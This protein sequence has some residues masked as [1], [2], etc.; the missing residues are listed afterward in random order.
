MLEIVL[1]K[2]FIVIL[3]FRILIDVNIF[4][5]EVLIYIKEKSFDLL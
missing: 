4:Y 1:N 5:E 3:Y 2:F